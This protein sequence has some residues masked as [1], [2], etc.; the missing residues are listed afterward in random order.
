MEKTLRS[1]NTSG[2]LLLLS[3]ACLSGRISGLGCSAFPFSGFQTITI[4]PWRP[5]DVYSLT[6]LFAKEKADVQLLTDECWKVP[7]LAQVP[8]S[9][10]W[11]LENLLVYIKKKNYP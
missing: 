2:H 5:C 9:F 10:E 11:A 3:C 1:N 7:L 4:T 6:L 8:F